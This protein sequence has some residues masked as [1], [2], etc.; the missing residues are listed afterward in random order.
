VTRYNEFLSFF[1]ALAR[2]ET[3]TKVRNRPMGRPT[4]GP[5]SVPRTADLCFL[6]EGH[7]R[8]VANRAPGRSSKRL[9]WVSRSP[10]AQVFRNGAPRGPSRFLVRFRQDSVKAPSGKKKSSSRSGSG[11]DYRARRH[12]GRSTHGGEFQ[13]AHR[14][15]ARAADSGADT[16]H[17]SRF[18]FFFCPFG[19]RTL[20]CELK[21]K[22]TVH[23]SAGSLR[24]PQPGDP[25]QALTNPNVAIEIG[26]KRKLPRALSRDPYC[27]DRS[28]P[29]NEGIGPVPAPPAAT[30]G[31]QN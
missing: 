24:S 18:G 13:N 25:R 6:D 11:Y 20:V 27:L 12:F 2:H 23:Y 28:K 14:G 7:P 3:S 26:R 31:R 10:K 9:A 1:S 30:A 15:A 22:F 17:R 16:R 8:T 19:H 5:R 4:P 21:K 29:P